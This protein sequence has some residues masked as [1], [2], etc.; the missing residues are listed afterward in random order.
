MSAFDVQEGG[1][2]YRK[3]PIQPV[4]YMIAN[5]IPYIEG[6]VIKYV[7]RWRDKNGIDDL[8]KARHLL[9]ILIECEGKGIFD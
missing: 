6:C 4:Q 5:G 3:L 9:D 2:H 1:D 8:K 7:T